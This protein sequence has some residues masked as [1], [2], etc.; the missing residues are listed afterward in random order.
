MAKCRR[1]SK[2]AIA[3]SLAGKL[4]DRE[5]GNARKEAL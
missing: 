1:S 3:S 4:V 5:I 2:L